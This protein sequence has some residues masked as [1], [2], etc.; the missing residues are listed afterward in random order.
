MI[1][2]LGEVF[3]LFGIVVRHHALAGVDVDLA[4][5]ICAP[6]TVSMSL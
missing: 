1:P 6:G 3:P 2:G 5:E 4:P